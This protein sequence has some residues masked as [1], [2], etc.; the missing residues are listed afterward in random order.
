MATGTWVHY[1]FKDENFNK[2][3]NMEWW[4]FPLRDTEIVAALLENTFLSAFPY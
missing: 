1:F 2:Y 3:A 4:V